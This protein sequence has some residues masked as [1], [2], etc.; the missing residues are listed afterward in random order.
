MI[1]PTLNE[2]EGIG[3]TLKELRDVLGDPY[4]LV[5]DGNST[6]NTIKIAK[7]MGAEILIQKGKGKGDALLEAF[8]YN[9]VNSNYVVMID[10]DGSM[11]PK[12][13]P[14]FIQALKSGADIAKGSRFLPNAHSKDLSLIRR[15]GN[16]IMV[17]L[18]NL[19]WSTNYT[20]LCYGFMAFKKEA[21]KSLS[22]YLSSRGFEIETEICIKAKKLGLKVVEVPSV[23]LKRKYGR[24]HLRTFRDGLRILVKIIREIF[25]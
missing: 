13:V 1:V 3:P 7:D 21:L 11:D 2:E 24:S 16:R 4:L 20:D 10:A 6:D 15:I 5:V 14:S 8:R 19:I 23:E 12:E 17:S 18:V 9:R 22:K 25:D